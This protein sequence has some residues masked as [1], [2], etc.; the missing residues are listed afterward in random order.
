M[1]WGRNPRGT[2]RLVLRRKPHPVVLLAMLPLWLAGCL[3]E[4]PTGKPV[5]RLAATWREPATGM[6]FVLVP[7]GG[8]RMGSPPEEPGRQADETPHEVVIGAWTSNKGKFSSL[9]VGVHRDGQLVYA[10]NVGT[11]YGAETVSRIM[12]ALKVAAAAKSRL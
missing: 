2:M 7:A 11:G 8:F 10:G 9:M 4:V 12:P 5:R 6:E 1:P 3:R